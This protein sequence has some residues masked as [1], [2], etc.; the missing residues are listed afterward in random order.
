MRFQIPE[1][2][3]ILERTPRVV[4]ALL[5]DQSSAWL[6][7]RIDP[8][9]FSPIDVLGHLIFGEI[10]DWIP[11]VRIILECQQSRAFDPFDRRGF[12][13][14]IEGKPVDELLRQFAALRDKN[15][16]ALHTFALDDAKLDL[17]GTHPELGSV[18][19]RQLLATWVVHDLN[20]IAQLMRILSNQ[21]RDEVGPWR[22]YLSIL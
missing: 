13:P 21:Y 6:D 19:L 22:A 16:E 15:I 20:H 8:A 17:P 3:A 18:T 4:D 14:L 10:T 5:R 2:I 11:R 12:A 9:S 7:A 1:A